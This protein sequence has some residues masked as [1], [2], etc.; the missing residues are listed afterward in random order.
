MANYFPPSPNYPTS[1][2]NE[3]TLF[4]VYNTS[5]TITTADNLPWD[6]EI[7][8][9][10]VAADQNEIWADNGF[11]N[12]DGE[13]FYYD[14][15][16]KD[17][18][19]KI[20]KFKRCARNLGG[21]HTK[22]NKIGSEVRGFVIAEHHNQ[23]ADAIINIENF[24][25]ENFST[26]KNTLDWRIRHL[27]SL[28]TIY[29]DFTCPDVSFDFIEKISV[30]FSCILCFFS[31]F[32]LGEEKK[33]FLSI[34]TVF[35]DEAPYLKEW[36]EYHK[37]L[38]V[39]HFRLYNNDSIDNYQEVLR[40][41]IEKGEVTLIDWPSNP[42]FLGVRGGW[43]YSTQLSA[44]FDAIRYFGGISKWLIL[45]L[46]NLNLQNIHGCQ[47]VLSVFLLFHIFYS[48]FLYLN[49]ILL[50][51][52]SQHH[53]FHINPMYH[54]PILIRIRLYLWFRHILFLFFLLSSRL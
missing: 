20:F 31:S 25:G 26:D 10:P 12:I 34:C 46:P 45:F 13:L 49:D 2:D 44:C 29:D 27:Q 11:A 22:H 54:Q 18:N 47:D 52:S 50:M 16:E 21:T 1:Y 28:P 24:V 5:E 33:F 51:L 36:I 38:G 37:L 4:L 39:E 19:G 41:Y 42:R 14:A 23:L 30:C 40:P 35:K 17:I 7:L 6:D 53:M 3:Y 15:V 48:H 43:A 32:V 9:K 8:I